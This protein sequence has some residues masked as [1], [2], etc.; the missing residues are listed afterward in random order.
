MMLRLDWRL[1]VIALICAPPSPPSSP[2]PARACAG[3]M[4]EVQRRLG[5][6]NAFLQ[7]RIAGVETVQIFGREA[8]RGGTLRGHQRRATIAPTSARPASLATMQPLIEFIAM[9]ALVMLIAVGGY[10]AITGPLTLGHPDH[11]WL[12]RP[13]ARSQPF[14]LGQDLAVRAT[15]RRGRGPRVRDH[16]RARGSAGGP[17]R[18]GA[19]P[20]GRPR[21]PFAMSPSP[22]AR[23]NRCCAGLNL[24]IE[25]G[26]VVALVGAS[27]AGKST[28]VR[29]IPRFYDPTEGH[30]E[31]DG[32]DIRTRRPG[33]L[34]GA[35]RHRSPGAHP[36]LRHPRREHRLW[37]AG[38][39]RGGDR[40]GRAGGQC[41]RV[42]RG[43]ARRL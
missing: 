29:L 20:G 40:G 43:P 24:S 32:V 31:V 10:L 36:L 14:L 5:D 15:S 19:S 25:A 22:I 4:L 9:V 26:Q 1:T 38:G 30:I 18:Q 2:A 8:G 39:H 21:S 23:G 17:A 28:L 12:P 16:G 34:A 13:E 7:E 27:G 42:H 11:L 41:G 35:D 33:L 3:L 37:E 6:L